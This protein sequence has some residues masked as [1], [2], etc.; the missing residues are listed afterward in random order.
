MINRQAH[1]S[2]D[3]ADFLR[4]L[5]L[6][7]DCTVTKLEWKPNAK[8]LKF[9]IKD[10]HFNFESLPEYR[11]PTLG[12]IVLEGAH[13]VDGQIGNLER[14]LRIYEFEVIEPNTARI[15]FSPAGQI[16]V[17]WERAICPIVAD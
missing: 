13:I 11:G 2:R 7:H 8:T 4:K 5:G 12:V 3:F 9:E 15:T 16:V 17:T 1:A 10:L 6:L 14:P